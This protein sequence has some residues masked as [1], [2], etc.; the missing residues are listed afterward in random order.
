MVDFRYKRRSASIALRA[1]VLAPMSLCFIAA[2]AA[3]ESKHQEEAPPANW[4]GV[5][6]GVHDGFGWGNTDWTFPLEEF[7]NVDPGDGFS[8]KPDGF[9]AGGHILLLRQFRRVVVGVEAAYSKGTISDDRVGVVTAAFP[10]DRF[11]TDIRDMGSISARLG[12]AAGIW[13]L[14]A[15]AGWASA[16]VQHNAWSGEPVAGVIADVGGRVNGYI[17][18]GGV[19]YMLTPDISVGVQYDFSRFGAKQYSTLTTGAS[20]GLPFNV[21]IDDI[22]VHAVTSRVSFRIGD[23]PQEL[24]PPHK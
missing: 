21:E 20:P 11:E 14:Y 19:E 10:E 16:E 5:Y 6:V 13:Q 23:W 4:S 12:Y 3:E 9:I 1:A 8:I 24:E 15:K 7:Y 22:T 17:V 2:A 18:G